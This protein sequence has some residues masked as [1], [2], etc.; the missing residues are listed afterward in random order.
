MDPDLKKAL[1]ALNMSFDEA[2]TAQ[3]NTL[4]EFRTTAEANA[5]SRDAV[6]D[7]KLKNLQDELAKFEPINAAINAAN[8]RAVADK[9]ELQASLDQIEARLNRPGNGGADAAAELR[10]KAFEA[11]ARKGN[12]A[13]T[14]DYQNVL[15]VSDDNAAG[16][17]AHPE[18][19]RTIL[20][21][22][23]EYS[24][25]RGL[26]SIR[27]TG[28]RSV[29]MPKRTGLPDAVWVGETQTRPDT[30]GLTFGMMEIP[31]HEA[32][33]AVP[34]TNQ[35]LEDSDFNL[36]DEIREA[37]VH[38]FAKQEAAAI[39]AGDKDGKPEGFLN[40]AGVVSTKSGTAATITSDA[41]LKLQFGDAATGKFKGTYAARGRYALNNATLGVIALLKDSDGQ[42]LYRVSPATDV[43]SMIG[44]KPYTVV[45]EMPD[46]GAGLK[47]VAFADWKQAYLL[48]DRL[49]MSMLR[50]DYTRAGNGQVLFR[51]RRR[52]GG[53]VTIAEAINVLSI[54]V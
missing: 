51:W 22:I 17:L 6:V 24:P 27:T 28:S 54:E 18:L 9:E 36:T 41:V 15:Q 53:A 52:L 30:E 3:N 2:V 21:N 4:A 20:K 33:M 37:V 46:I 32:T 11:F 23:E 1:D 25:L 49:A 14:G 35:M 44:G 42:Y 7:E 8:E 31:V 19:V 48:V 38:A 12:G 5:K 26:V 45:H 50:D 43:S 39:V 13:L 47:P 40:A 16:V 29:Q 10:E 34:V